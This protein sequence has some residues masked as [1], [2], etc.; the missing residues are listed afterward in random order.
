[1]T[2]RYIASNKEYRKNMSDN[3]AMLHKTTDSPWV[4]SVNCEE[5]QVLVSNILEV[6]A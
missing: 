3:L 4:N 1:M 5:S 2:V 6:Q